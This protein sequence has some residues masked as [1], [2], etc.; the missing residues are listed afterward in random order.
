MHYIE[1]SHSSES[2]HSIRSTLAFTLVALL[3]AL[4]LWIGSAIG[5]APSQ[6]NTPRQNRPE[7]GMRQRFAAQQTPSGQSPSRQSLVEQGTPQQSSSRQGTP[8]RSPVQQSPPAAPIRDVPDTYYG[9]VVDDPYRYMEN[10][11]DRDV[12]AWIKAQSDF[13]RGI[14]DRIPGRKPLLERIQAIDNAVSARVWDVRRLPNGLYFYLKRLP[15]DNT[16][17]LYARGGLTGKETLLVDPDSLA[18]ATGKPHAIN[19]FEPSWDGTHVAYGISAAGSEDA[20]IHVI[21]T[22]TGKEVDT[23]IDRAQFGEVNWRPDG[24][25]FFYNRLQK[26]ESGMD[27]TE[28]YQKS[29]VYLHTIGNEPDKDEPVFGFDISAAVKMLTSDIPMVITRPGS[30]Y[31]VGLI[32]HGTQNEA[33]LYV[34]PLVTVGV[35]NTPWRKVCDVEDGVTG[36]SVSGENIFLLTHKEAPRFRIIKTSLSQPDIVSAETV[37]PP[38]E[39]VVAGLACAKDALYV[40]VR[41][42]VIGRLLRVPPAGKPEQVQLPFDGSV[43]LSL[44][45]PRCNGVLIVMAAWTKAAQI[46][47]YDPRTNKVT[48]TGLQPLGRFDAPGNIESAEVKAKSYDGTMVPLSIIYKRGIKLDGSNPTLLYGYG[49][50]GITQ[51][52]WL[53]PRLLAWLERGGIYA[54]AHV[55]GGGEYGEEWYKAGY[56]STKPNTWRDFIA[57]AEYLIQNKYTSPQRLAGMG[58]SAGGILIGRA[59]TERPDLFGAAIPEVGALDMVRA[60]TTPN[61]IPN[62]PEFGSVKTEE[63]FKALYEMSSYHH[64][65]KGTKYPAVMLTHGINDPRVEPWQSA[66]MAARLQ[67]LTASGKPVLL[68]IDYEAGHGIG[69]TKKQIQQEMADIWAFLFWQFGVPGFQPSPKK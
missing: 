6:Q 5:G 13:T 21:E 58:G 51:E 54:V 38:G 43:N 20:V 9:R 24:R 16:F 12:Q 42:G 3:C 56:K 11:S 1:P 67:A 27:P 65:V 36:F 50:Y 35:A 26:L 46:Y 8:Q 4:T 25:S 14:L 53:T 22:S 63:G 33:T 15:T 32:A 68:R 41:E 39:A 69:T 31:A 57:C 47:D 60:E 17:K 19:Y 62:I 30:E 49:A 29:R 59:I 55:R 18:K 61:G 66:K 40:Q 52:P 37:V 44:T 23:P 64:V 45:D 28:R 48:N 10:L 7:Q 2:S 34:T